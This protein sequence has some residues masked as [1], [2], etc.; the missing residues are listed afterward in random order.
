MLLFRLNTYICSSS[1]QPLIQKGGGTVPFD[2]LATL[3]SVGSSS[4][5]FPATETRASS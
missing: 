3:D 4:W 5:Q 1:L 2:A